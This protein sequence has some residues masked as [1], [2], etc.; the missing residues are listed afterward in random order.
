MSLI[1]GHEILSVFRTGKHELDTACI[2]YTG[3]VENPH[4]TAENICLSK[5]KSHIKI[6]LS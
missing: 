5:D 1:N 3:F 2:I 4:N 6:Y